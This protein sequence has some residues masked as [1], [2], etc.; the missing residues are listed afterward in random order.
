MLVVLQDI[1]AK[2][3]ILRP[4]PGGVAHLPGTF[5]HLAANHDTGGLDVKKHS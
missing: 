3:N 2:G 1:S 4:K 5:V